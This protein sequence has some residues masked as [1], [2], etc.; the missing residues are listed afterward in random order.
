MI[1]RLTIVY[2]KDN[3]L[4]IDYKYV[5]GM[6]DALKVRNHIL[7]YENVLTVSSPIEWF[8]AGGPTFSQKSVKK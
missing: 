2:K 1:Y 6:I 5:M 8:G 7:K 3:L 4:H